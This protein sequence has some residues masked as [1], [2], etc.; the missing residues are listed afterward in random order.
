MPIRMVQWL[1]SPAVSTFYG[2][3]SVRAL[4][5]C[6]G[7]MQIEQRVDG[8]EEESRA[9]ALPMAYALLGALAL[10][11]VL[12]DQLT[13]AWISTSLGTRGE[14]ELLGGLV[15]IHYTRNSGAAFGIFPAGGLLFAVVS[16]L[17]SIGIVVYYRRAARGPVLVRLGLGL[18]L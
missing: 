13:K 16:V 6:R 10:S 17:V 15:Q 18:I 4:H 14:V 1:P 7:V 2:A 3:A 11:V 9:P 12:F 5:F 8:A